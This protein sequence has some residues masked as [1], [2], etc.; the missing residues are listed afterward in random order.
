MNKTKNAEFYRERWEKMVE[1]C[2][3]GVHPS[4]FNSTILHADYRIRLAEVAMDVLINKIKEDR[5][6]CPVGDCQL[7]KTKYDCIYNLEICK[8]GIHRWAIN[9]A[10][11]TLGEK[12]E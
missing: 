8:K 12:H 6:Y 11:T 4:R 5:T 3:A 9:E 10:K 2:R 7:G 1:G